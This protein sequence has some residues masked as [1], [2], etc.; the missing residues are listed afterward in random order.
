MRAD[1]NTGQ[2]YDDFWGWLLADLHV[3]W[4]ISL[5]FAYVYYLLTTEEV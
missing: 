1:R 4:I 2:T 3:F 5:F